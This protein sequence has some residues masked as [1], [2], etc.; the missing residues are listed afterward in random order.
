[1]NT[2]TLRFLLPILVAAALLLPLG[3]ATAQDDGLQFCL[4]V[5]DDP[6]GSFWSVVDRGA[7]DAAA[8][9]GADLTSG[10]SLDPVVQAQLSKTVWRR[11]WMG[12][13]SRWR[14]LTRCAIRS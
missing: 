3:P 1:M 9:Y 5:H 10:G 13:S 7:K 14:T 6:T 8:L 2:R 12:S 4:A 11:A